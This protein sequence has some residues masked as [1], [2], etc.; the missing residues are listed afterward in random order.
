MRCPSRTGSLSLVRALDV[1][2]SLSLCASRMLFHD[3]TVN[4]AGDGF[5]VRGRAATTGDCTSP[6][7]RAA[8]SRASVSGLC[9]GAALERRSLFAGIGLFDEAFRTLVGLQRVAGTARRRGYRPYG[10]R[11]GAPRR[12]RHPVRRASPAAPK[13]GGPRS[14]GL[15]ARCWCPSS[16]SMPRRG[17]PKNVSRREARAAS[18]ARPFAR[19]TPRVSSAQRSRRIPVGRCC[20]DPA[21]RVAALLA[22]GRAPRGRTRGTPRRAGTAR[23]RPAAPARSRGAARR[24]STRASPSTPSATSLRDRGRAT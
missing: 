14:R 5:E 7:A 19:E 10:R 13:Q 8:T 1:D 21:V 12:A 3:G 15:P 6:M 18:R 11:S 24:P 4:A 9:A 22:D 23:A 17:T 20:P 2:A 16:R